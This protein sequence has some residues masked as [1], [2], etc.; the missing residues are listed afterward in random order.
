M[1]LKIKLWSIFLDTVQCQSNEGLIFLKIGGQL[2][3]FGGG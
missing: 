1:G 3:N 2:H